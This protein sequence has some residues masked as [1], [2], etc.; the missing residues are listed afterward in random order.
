VVGFNNF[1]AGSEPAV[2]ALF[3]VLAYDVLAVLLLRLPRTQH[4]SVPRY[5]PP[6]GA[7]PGVAAWLFDGGELPRAMAAALVNMAAKGYLQIDQTGDCCSVTQL[8]TEFSM[9]QPEEDALA[10]SL[11]QD[12]DCFDFEQLTPALTKAV[13]AFRWALQDTGYLTRNT[14]LSIPAWSVSG[15]AIPFVLARA[16]H[17]SHITRDAGPYLAASILITFF[18][19]FLSV[20]TFPATL[21]KIA[22]RFPSSTAPQRPWTGA[23]TRSV[24]FLCA[25]LG[26]IALLGLLTTVAAA[27]LT[28]AFLAVN[29]VFFDALQAPTSKGRQLIADLADYKKFLAEVDADAISRGNPSAHPPAQLQTKEAYALAFHLDLGWGEQFVTSIADLIESAEVRP[30]QFLTFR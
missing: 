17:S 12:Y 7:S 9:L 18:S 30:P 22:S 24:T 27:L 8:R 4:T 21:E 16:A 19:F 20:R 25:T 5:E 10:R 6:P 13:T 23:D 29:A 2:A 28:A 1:I 26:G 15:L 14:W 3:F 11:F